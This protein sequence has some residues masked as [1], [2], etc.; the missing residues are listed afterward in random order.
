ARPR[1]AI[2]P[3][4]PRPRFCRFRPPR[5]PLEYLTSLRLTLRILPSS[6]PTLVIH[7]R[8]LRVDPPTK[9]HHPAVDHRAPRL[10]RDRRL[11]RPQHHRPHGGL[12]VSHTPIQYDPE[13][14]APDR[15]LVASYPGVTSAS[16]ISSAPAGSLLRPPFRLPI[17]RPRRPREIVR[18]GS[19]LLP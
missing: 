9:R 15:G 19:P 8:L 6:A 17:P 13:A 2:S 12:I 18:R 5:H 1:V 3:S 11:R 16:S 7:C 14:P 10:H 4:L